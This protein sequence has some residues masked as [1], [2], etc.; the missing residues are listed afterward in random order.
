MAGEESK[1]LVRRAYEEA[2]NKKNLDALDEVLPADY[3]LHRDTAGRRGRDVIKEGIAAY[4]VAFP[5]LYV[6][7]EQLVAEGEF[8]VMRG[9]W[10]GTHLGTM[11]TV[12]GPMPPTGREMVWT[13]THLFRIAEGRIVEA[14]YQ[15]D[16]LAF[17]QQLGAIPVPPPPPGT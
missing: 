6:T 5:D 11:R 4:H 13:G 17:Y 16:W 10:R 14:F 9:T 8:V 12:Y 7:I 15:T 3:D 1:A 2:W